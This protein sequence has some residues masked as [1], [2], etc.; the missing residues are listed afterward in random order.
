L[1]EQNKAL[2]EQIQAMTAE[3]NTAAITAFT[4]GLV[5]AGKVLPAQVEGLKAIALSSGLDAV[6]KLYEAAPAVVSLTEKGITGKTDAG[7]D[8]KAA[9][10]RIDV[11]VAELRKVD[12]ALSFQAAY[13]VALS[14]MPE[15]SAALYGPNK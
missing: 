7:V 3:K 12:P 14:E 13:S 10:G 2:T 11:R 4:D 6:A 15:V 1:A 5:K 8:T 9:Q